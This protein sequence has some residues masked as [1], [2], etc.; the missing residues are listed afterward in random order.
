MLVVDHKEQPLVSWRPGN[1]TMRHCSETLGAEHM[2]AGEQW[3]EPGTGAPQHY[4]PEGIEEVIVVLEGSARFKVDGEELV[5]RAGQSIILPPLCHHGF[6]A[7]EKLHIGGGG[8]SSA[9]QTTVFDD[10]PDLIYDI[11]ATQGV[12]LDEHRRLRT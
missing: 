12:K 2:T 11:G 3:F 5:V 9:V 8:L 4:H 10:E 6:V 7:L 1:V